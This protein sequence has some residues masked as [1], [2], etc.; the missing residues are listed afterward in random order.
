LLTDRNQEAKLDVGRESLIDVP[1]DY[2]N[3]SARALVESLRSVGYSLPT[4][5]ADVIDNSITANANNVWVDFHWSGSRSSITILDDGRGMT[6]P[7]LV[8]AMRPGTTSPTATRDGSDLGRFGLGLKTA[9]FSQCRQLTVWSKSGGTSVVGRRWDLDYV[10]R[11]NEWRLQKDL[12]QPLDERFLEL[13]RL[14][15]GT[16]VMW[17]RVD[18]LVDDDDMAADDAHQKFLTQ[19]NDVCQYLAMIFHRHLT[20]KA[21]HRRAALN[22]CINGTRLTGWDPFHVSDNVP[23][24]RSPVDS[25]D[26]RGQIVRVQGYVMPH[27]DRLSERE[28]LEGAGPRGWIAQQGFYIYRND[29]MLLAGDWLRLGR[30]GRSWPKEEQ[31]KLARLS[32]DIG[33]SMDL[34]WS[35]DV[36]KSTARPPAALRVRLTGL[37]EGQRKRAKEVFVYRGNYGPRPPVGTMIIERPWKSSVRVERIIYQI[38]REHPMVKGVFQRLGPLAAEVESV[39]RLIEETVPVQKIWIDTA[40]SDKDH[41]IPYEGISDAQLMADISTTYRFLRQGTLDHN[42]AIAYLLASEPFNRFPNLVAL[43]GDSGGAA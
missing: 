41:A 7:I 4:A 37:A 12:D 9:S 43:V 28:Y 13:R 24:E 14:G 22:I 25:I 32:I 10:V 21:A 15:H 18:R 2:A 5:I 27:K 35:L 1:Y 40:E 17:H 38:N 26:Y 6:E 42:S 11:H 33:N 20:G 36:K 34:E 16:L 8:E 29:R 31:Y 30:G 23:A 3:P 39:F 19:I